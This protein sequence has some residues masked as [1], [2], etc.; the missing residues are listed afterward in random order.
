M[1]LNN[2]PPRT[3]YWDDTP[4]KKSQLIEDKDIESQTDEVPY[5]FGKE[6]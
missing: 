3:S 1:S 4:I 2:Q 5:S 6:K